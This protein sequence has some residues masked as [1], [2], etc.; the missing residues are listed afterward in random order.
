VY[1]G[2]WIAVVA[3]VVIVVALRVLGVRNGW[4]SAVFPAEHRRPDT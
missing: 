3:T 1:A 4:T 2:F